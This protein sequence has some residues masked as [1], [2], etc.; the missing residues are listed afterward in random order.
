MLVLTGCSAR[1]DDEAVLTQQE[2]KKI[3][4]GMIFDTFVVERWERDRDIFVSTAMELGAEVNVQNANGDVNEQIAQMEYFIDKK[5][6]VIVLVPIESS[7][8][9]PSIEKAKNAGIKVIS[10]DRLVLGGGVDLYVSFDNEEVGRLMA[11]AVGSQ[12]ETGD[13]VLMICGPNS[14]NN[15]SLVEKGFQEGLKEDGLEIAAVFHADDWRAEYAA[16][17]MEQYGE[18]IYNIRAIM[19]GNDNLAGRVINVLSRRRLAG[20]VCVVAQDADLEACQ[21]IVEG[22]QYMTVYKSVEKLAVEAAHAAVE[23]AQGQEIDTQDQIDDGSFMVPY[24]KLSPTAVTAGNMDDTIIKS[25]FHLAED[26]YL[27]RPDL[28]KNQ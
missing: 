11:Q 12:L 17:F 21:R 25:G 1:E 23:L 16:D 14:D 22:T 19:C 15:V 4:I 7:A 18:E 20:S 26:V 24:I 3:Q 13:Q 28:L 9:V 5:V 8:L 27:N 6:D 2:E 10:Y